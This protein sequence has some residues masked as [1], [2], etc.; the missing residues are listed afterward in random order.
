M[1]KPETGTSKCCFS[2]SA[3]LRSGGIAESRAGNAGSETGAPPA[4]ADV[5]GSV[6]LRPPLLSGKT[7]TCLFRREA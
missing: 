7:H 4:N 3:G 2:A 5:G 1:T 6:K